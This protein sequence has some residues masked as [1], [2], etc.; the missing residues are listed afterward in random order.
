M[1]PGLSKRRYLQ[2]LIE[3]KTSKVKLSGQRVLHRTKVEKGVPLHTHFSVNPH[4]I[5]A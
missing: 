3:N 1:K 4:S 5:V 2:K